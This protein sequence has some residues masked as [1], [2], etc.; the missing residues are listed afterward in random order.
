[1]SAPE[2]VD[3]FLSGFQV[4]IQ[5]GDSLPDVLSDAIIVFWVLMNHHELAPFSLDVLLLLHSF[6]CFHLEGAVDAPE[7]FVQA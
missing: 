6:H 7:L 4:V 5:P 2:E 1:M 3:A